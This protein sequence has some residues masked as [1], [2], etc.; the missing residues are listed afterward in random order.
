MGKTFSLSGEKLNINILL[1]DKGK[2]FFCLGENQNIILEK[3]VQKAME[4]RFII[5]S[6]FII[7]NRDL[8][9]KFGVNSAILLG[10]LYG[11]YNYF[12]K[13]NQLKNG[14]FFAT[15]NSIESST[16]LTPY[17]QRTASSILENA[18]ILEVKYIDIPPK[19]YYRINEIN[20][21]KVLK[22]SV[23]ENMNN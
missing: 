7:A 16:K 10:E 8:I 14:F 17:K 5:Q 19:T 1:K 23:V 9:N 13:R 4:N 21:L 12:K 6:N 2:N 18:N 20:L 3:G 15:K 22:N 11:R